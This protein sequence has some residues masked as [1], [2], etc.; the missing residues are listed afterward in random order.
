VTTKEAKT[1][2]RGVGV[3]W[4]ADAKKHEPMYIQAAFSPVASLDPRLGAETVEGAALALEGVD[5]VEG[6]DRLALGVLGVGDRVAD[7]RL[8]LR[9]ER[10]SG[11]EMGTGQGRG[12]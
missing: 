6:R 10:G 12:W 9:C 7:D 11:T 4:E 2:R 8:E 5:D 3:G 1:K